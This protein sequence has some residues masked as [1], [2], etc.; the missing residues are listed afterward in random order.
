MVATLAWWSGRAQ[1]HLSGDLSTEKQQQPVRAE[2]R[3][4]S[5]SSWHEAL[6]R[7]GAGVSEDQN[8]GWGGLM[9]WE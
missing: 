7:D 8:A 4:T 3:S 2:Q 6:G 5:G 9:P 1:S